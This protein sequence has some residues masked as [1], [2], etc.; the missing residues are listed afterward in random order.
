MINYFNRYQGLSKE[1]KQRIKWF[2][3]YQQRNNIA[4]TCRYFG[5]SRQC[6]YEWK[7]KYNPKNLWSLE[8]GSTA[9]KHKRQREITSEQEIRIINLRRQHIRYSKIKLAKIYQQLYNEPIS[10]WKVQKVI[11]KRQLYYHPKRQARI[12]AKRFKANKKRRIT[13][14]KKKQQRAGFLW[15]LDVVVIYWNGIK[16]YLFTA[17]DHYSKVAFTRMYSTKSSLNAVDF[18]NRLLYLTNGK[19]ENIQTDNGSEFEKHFALACQKLQLSR[20]Y[21]R[22]HTPKDNAVNERFNQTLQ[23]EFINLGNFTIDTVAFNHSLT[24]WL[25]EYNFYR[26]HT[27]LNYE[28]PIKLP[29]YNTQVSPMW[30]SYTISL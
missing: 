27:T 25:I 17:I 9:P 29:I 4:Q 28:T 13:E 1:A 30:S 6:F 3:Y 5:I 19:I 10:S 2:D 21:N 20:Y 26:P 22:P 15:C 12:T 11:E 18:L 16:R 14:L 23:T 8:N 24:D 7:K